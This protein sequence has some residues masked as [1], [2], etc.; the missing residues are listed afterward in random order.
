MGGGTECGS[1]GAEGLRGG[2]VFFH[3]FSGT[4]ALHQEDSFTGGCWSEDSK[5]H[6]ALSCSDS[7]CGARHR[8]PDDL[9]ALGERKYLLLEATG[10]LRLCSRLQP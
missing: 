8:G 5:R 2:M 4:P 10:I 3:G 9:Q 6:V 7:H 1:M